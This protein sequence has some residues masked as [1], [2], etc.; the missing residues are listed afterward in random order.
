MRLLNQI[1]RRYKNT[2]Y[3]KFWVVI[4][5]SIITK[6]NWKK[7]QELKTEIKDKKL[8]VSKNEK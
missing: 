7:G 4:P 2:K 6:L 3:E 8:I 5:S 1:S